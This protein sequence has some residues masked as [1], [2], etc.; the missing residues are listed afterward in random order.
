MP[1]EEDAFVAGVVVLEGEGG[2]LGGVAAVEHGDFGGAEADGGDGG[3]DGGV[4]GA[5]HGYPRWRGGYGS[6]FVAGDEF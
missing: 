2:H 6:V 5:Y 1:V 3:V 4:A